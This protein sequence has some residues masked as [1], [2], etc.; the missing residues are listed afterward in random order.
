MTISGRAGAIVLC[1]AVAVAAAAPWLPLRDPSAQPDGLVLRTLPPLARVYRI[2]R[3]GEEPTYANALRTLPGGGREIRR[4][5]AWT[6]V[7]LDG[8]TVRRP[9]YLLGTDGYGR[10]LLSRIVWGARASLLAG[11]LAALVALGLGGAI[12]LCAG[13]GPGPVDAILMRLTDGALAV[14]RLFLLVLVAALFRPSLT[15]TVLII[16]ASTWMTAARLVRGETISLAAREFVLAARAAGAGPVRVALRH[17]LPGLA[18]ILAVE[19]AVRFGQSILLE[20]ALSFL[21]LG[22]PPPAPTWGSLI[23]DGR[24][25]LLDA[26]WIATWPGLALASCVVAATLLADAGED[27]L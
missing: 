14:P 5:D 16:G 3:P 22:V 13:L 17:V 4:G 1:A 15:T 21:G 23:A 12:G 7:S 8:A 25:R 18:P 27:R 20:A 19:A 2:E 26:W 11:S 6:P 10:D 9:L 24:D